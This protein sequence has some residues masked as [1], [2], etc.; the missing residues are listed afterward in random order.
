MPRIRNGHEGDAALH[1][2]THLDEYTKEINKRLVAA[3]E[4]AEKNGH[5]QKIILNE[6]NRIR[7]DL[8]MVF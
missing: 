8:L 5:D 6:L 4:E 3:N 7:S 1:S 2:G